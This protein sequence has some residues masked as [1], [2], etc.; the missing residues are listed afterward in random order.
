MPSETGVVQEDGVPFLPSISTTHS[1]HDPKAFR[2][3]VAHNFGTSIPASSAARM[4]EVSAGTQ[5]C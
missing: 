1:L 4:I 5:I 3:S 2:R